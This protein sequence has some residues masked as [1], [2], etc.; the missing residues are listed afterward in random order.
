MKT[1]WAFVIEARLRHVCW[2]SVTCADSG[3]RADTQT[4]DSWAIVDPLLK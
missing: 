2:Y 1:T 4:R 3:L